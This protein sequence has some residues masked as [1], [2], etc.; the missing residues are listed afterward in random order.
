MKKQSPSDPLIPRKMLTRRRLLKRAAGVTV[1]A[2]AQALM[3]FNVR[4]VLAQ[5]PPKQGSLDDIKHVVLLMQENRSLDHYFGTLAGARGFSDPKAHKLSN[6][7]SVFYQ[8]D[9]ENPDGY[10]LPFHLDTRAT[11]AQKIPSTS[12]AWAVQHEAWNYGEM[13]LWLPAH[14][15]ADGANGPYCMGYY[16]RSD[17]PFQFALAESFTLCDEYFCSVLGPTWPNRMCWMTGT[18][19]PEGLGGGPITSNHAPPGGYTWTTYPERLDEAGISWKVY[20]QEDNYGC[21]M[22]ENFKNFQ[23]ASR[24]SSLYSNGMLHGQEGHFEYDAINDKLPTVSWIIPTSFQSEHPDYMPAD[25]AAFV[26][27]KIDAIAAN[28]DVWAKTLFILN[29]DENDGIFDH[30]PPPDSTRRYAARI[31]RRASDRRRIPRSLHSDLPV[32]HRRMGVQRRIRSYVGPLVLGAVHRRARAEYQR[33]AAAYLRRYDLRA[34]ISRCEKGTA[35]A[36]GYVWR[37]PDRRV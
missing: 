29:Y 16:M 6:G 34:A 23:Q 2:A 3:P 14:R 13:D 35:R 37:P 18:I 20:Q 24:G 15:K 27:S 30:V 12:H 22:L 25:G 10:L 19:D 1:A 26:A 31:C 11:S 9:A 21:N 17:I 5:G 28:P 33:M 7:R 36:A 32:D 8:P 4:R